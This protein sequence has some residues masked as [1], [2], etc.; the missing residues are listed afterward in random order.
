MKDLL[1]DWDGKKAG[2]KR[3]MIYNNDQ[4]FLR[5]MVWPCIQDNCLQ[6][7]FC[8]GDLFR[9]THPFPARLGEWRFCGERIL[10]NE[11]PEP[12]SWEKRINWMT[13]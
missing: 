2:G 13:P 9:G 8:T 10:P 11:Q 12:S 5:D 4:L 3:E 1:S 6:H 7:D